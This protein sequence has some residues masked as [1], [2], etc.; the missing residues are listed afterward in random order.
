MDV[1]VQ[2]YKGLNNDASLSPVHARSTPAL[3]MLYKYYKYVLMLV[4]YV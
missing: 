2:K 4:I 1:L 3:P